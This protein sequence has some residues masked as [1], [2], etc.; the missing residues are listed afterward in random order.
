LPAPF[1]FDESAVEALTKVSA[2]SLFA[3]RDMVSC[4]RFR[5]LTAREMS[6]LPDLE[7]RLDLIGNKIQRTA[8]DIDSYPIQQKAQSGQEWLPY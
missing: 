7:T 1:L 8:K 3:H 5:T 2:D 6:K 4:A